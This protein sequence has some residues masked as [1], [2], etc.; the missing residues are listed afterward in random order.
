MEWLII[1]GILLASGGLII[2]IAWKIEDWWPMSIADKIMGKVGYLGIL[3]GV[4][5]I[6]STI[7]CPVHYY[8]TRTDALKAEAYYQQIALPQMV[9]EHD[10]Y[11]VVDSAQAGIW[12]AGEWNMARYN[13]YLK[14][15]RYWDS[16]P[17]IGTAIYGPPEYL[18]YVRVN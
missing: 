2:L 4:L 1:P 7:V 10:N 14:S 15:T 6:A 11:I 8:S 12:Q 9:E 16:I 17:I 13:G 18:K 3:I 5:F